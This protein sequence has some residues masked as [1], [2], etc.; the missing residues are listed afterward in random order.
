MSAL[1]VW[2]EKWQPFLQWRWSDYA[3][4]YHWQPA[5]NEETK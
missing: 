4:E 5:L 1:W 2:E 3:W